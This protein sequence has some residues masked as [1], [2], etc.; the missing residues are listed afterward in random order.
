MVSKHIENGDIEFAPVYFNFTTK[1][2]KISR[3]MSVSKT[4]T[5]L[6]VIRQSV[7]IK[8]H[9]SKYCLQCFSSE[10]VLAEHKE[11]CLKIN[12]EE[13]LKLRGSIKLKNLFKQLA[14]PFKI[15]TEFQC[16][17][18]RVWSSDRNNNTS[19]TEKYQTHTPC[20]FAYKVVCVQR[21]K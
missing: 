18:K 7:K 4:L 5:D 19:Y 1:T 6:C 14:V 12:R 16:N 8:K 9:F 13:T 10:G 15:Y 3:M 20:N 17:V 2:V 21:K 11:T